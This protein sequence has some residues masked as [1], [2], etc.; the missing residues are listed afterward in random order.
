VPRSRQRHPFTGAVRIRARELLR[1][2]LVVTLFLAQA[3]A[4]AVISGLRFV[5]VYA[6]DTDA[7]L[8]LDC[9]RLV[10]APG[11]LLFGV[12]AATVVG[13]EFNWATERALLARD[14]RRPRFVAM[15]LAIVTALMV[16]WT[17]VQCAFAVG[18]GTV[19]RL[20]I[21]PPGVEFQDPG[22]LA[23]AVAAAAAATAFYG[24]FGAACALGFRGG[25]AGVFGVLSYGLLVELLLGSRWR[26]VAQWSVRSAATSL[27]GQGGL[28]TA[29]AVAVLGGSALVA[30]VAAFVVY[31]G[32][33]VRE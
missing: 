13:A 32:R 25:L 2:P 4:V 19:L 8:V 7:S 30:L 16:V 26:S 6:S 28:P 5:D 14:P 23:L 17:L 3:V 21:E 33:E 24:L 15:Q 10:V 11:G 12:L 9:L 20:L 27:T 1:R 31:S 29:E 22:A 18:A